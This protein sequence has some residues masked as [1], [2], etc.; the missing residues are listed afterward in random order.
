MT[1][2]EELRDILK[3]YGARWQGSERAAFAAAE[4]DDA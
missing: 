4:S 1:D 3:M 2:A